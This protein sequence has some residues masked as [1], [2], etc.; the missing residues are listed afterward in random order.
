[1]TFT[2]ELKLQHIVGAVETHYNELKLQTPFELITS[3][4]FQSRCPNR[5]K[6]KEIWGDWSKGN[7]CCILKKQDGEVQQNFQLQAHTVKQQCKCK[8][9]HFKF[10]ENSYITTFKICLLVCTNQIF[11]NVL[12]SSRVEWTLYRPETLNRGFY[13]P[14]GGFF[15][16]KGNLVSPTTD[17]TEK[18][19]KNIAFVSDAK[20]KTDQIYMSSLV[21]VFFYSF[22]NYHCWQCS[23]CSHSDFIHYCKKKERGLYTLW[24]FH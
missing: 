2:F 18:A 9:R 3:S 10:I 24:P 22:C 21:V 6:K 15:L 11:L 12:L 13:N 8:Q 23:H 19:F 20:N 4:P 5:N 14:C 17:N 16:V 7:H 1:M